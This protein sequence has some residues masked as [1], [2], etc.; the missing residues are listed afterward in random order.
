MVLLKENLE[1]KL[2]TSETAAK[3]YRRPKNTSFFEKK[4]PSGLKWLIALSIVCTLGAGGFLYSKMHK[5][6]KKERKTSL[7]LKELQYKRV[8]AD[9]LGGVPIPTHLANIPFGEDSGL[10][11]GVRSLD[12]RN[13]I[14]PHNPALVKSAS[15]Y[16]LFFRYDLMSSKARHLPYFS[17][18]GVVSLDNHFSQGPQ[19]FQKIELSND[20]TEDPRALWVGDQLF[21]VYNALDLEGLKGRTMCL[22]NIDPSTYKANY[23]TTIDMNLSWVEKNWP[24]FAYGPPAEDPNL[25][26]EYQIIPRKIISLPDPQ[27]NEILNITLPRKVAYMSLFWEKIWGQIR[28]GTP[29]VKIGDEYLAFFHSAFTERSGFWW[30]VMGAYTF[31]AEPPFALTGISTRPILFRGIFDTPIANTAEFRKRVI[32]PSGF[33]IE[34]QDGKELIHLACG[35]NDSGIKIVTLDKEV[36]LNNLHR[37]DGK[38]KKS[39]HS[40]LPQLPPVGQHQ[41]GNH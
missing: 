37:L 38:A 12:I 22:A 2:S 34:K 40:N 28:G 39:S 6:K 5:M 32:F 7:A 27:K 26:F 16:D 36:L 30:Y 14:A 31:Q 21:L 35:E 10:V 18:I 8:L 11:L 20:Y 33:V 23:T 25:F 15:G 13:V 4:S 19:E 17:H 3:H 9:C 24:P 41:N 1:K 29:A